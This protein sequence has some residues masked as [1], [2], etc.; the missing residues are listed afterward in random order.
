MNPAATDGA[1]AWFSG[2][3]RLAAGFL[4]ASITA[5]L[6]MLHPGKTLVDILIFCFGRTA[7]RIIGVFYLLFAIWLSGV[8][9]LTFSNYSNSVSYPETPILVLSRSVIC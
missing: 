5:A 7:G 4:L 6:A 2:L 8:V 9:L 3:V 1:D